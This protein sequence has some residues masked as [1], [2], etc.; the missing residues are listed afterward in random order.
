MS[1]HSPSTSLSF[2]RRIM[3][4]A[5]VIKNRLLVLN[6]QY[7]SSVSLDSNSLSLTEH[8]WWT[9]SP[10]R[11][12]LSLSTKF[13]APKF[14]YHYPCTTLRQQSLNLIHHSLSISKVSVQ[15]RTGRQNV[16]SFL[17]GQNVLQ[18]IVCIRRSPSLSPHRKQQINLSTSLI[19]PNGIPTPSITYIGRLTKVD[20]IRISL[21]A[22]ERVFIFHVANFFLTLSTRNW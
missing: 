11:T 18:F 1:L 14:P 21:A 2:P 4:F 5:E 22:L 16:P 13:R 19:T 20:R 10:C 12:P 3:S 8:N 15:N 7:N 6:F 17:G 9:T